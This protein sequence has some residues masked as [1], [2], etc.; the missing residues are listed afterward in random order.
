MVQLKLKMLSYVS[1]TIKSIEMFITKNICSKNLSY[2][3]LQNQ[4]KL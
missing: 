1:E 2:I 3:Q 4:L